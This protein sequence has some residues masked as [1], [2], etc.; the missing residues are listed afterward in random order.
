MP[1][2][3]KAVERGELD[4]SDVVDPHAPDLGPVHPGEIL[5]EE[6]L[7]PLGLSAGALAEAVHVPEQEV[8]SLLRGEKAL[9]ANMA[10]RLGRLFGTAPA[11]WLGL[12]MDYDLARA[13]REQVAIEDVIPLR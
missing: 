11:F 9:S 7:V 5:R 12:Q 13:S 4:F 10:L 2:P 3:L 8:E 1:N 6:Y